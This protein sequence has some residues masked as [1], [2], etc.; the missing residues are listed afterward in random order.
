MTTESNFSTSIPMLFMAV[1]MLGLTIAVAIG[2]VTAYRRAS[3]PADRRT[4]VVAIAGSTLILATLV[5][6]AISSAP[7]GA[8]VP[9]MILELVLLGTAFWVWILIDCATNAPPGTI[10]S[11]GCWSSC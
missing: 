8:L 2:G 6:G 3:L 11:S 5:L 4:A 1:V 9:L 10:S 7:G